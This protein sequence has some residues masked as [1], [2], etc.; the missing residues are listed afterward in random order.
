M[1]IEPT[2]AL[3]VCIRPHRPHMP[4]R[5]PA[6]YAANVLARFGT[7][8]PR[9]LARRENAGMRASMNITPMARMQPTGSST[10][11]QAIRAK[12]REAAHRRGLRSMEVVLAAMTGPVARPELQAIT[13]LPPSTIQRALN[14]ALSEDMVTRHKSRG[15]VIWERRT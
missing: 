3:T 8:D 1:T 4:A 6:D 15:V 11:S 9:E 2:A 5:S 14:R 13:G 12:L 10:V 7:L